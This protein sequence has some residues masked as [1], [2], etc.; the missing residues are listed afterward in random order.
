MSDDLVAELRRSAAGL[1]GREVE[2]RDLRRIP[3]GA[4]HETWSCDV[5]D[6]ARVHPVIVRRDIAGGL[7]ETDGPG[8]FALLGTLHEL[9]QPVPRQWLRTADLTVME[10]VPGRDA[11]KLMADSEREFDARD[12]GLQLVGIQAGLH[13]V[14]WRNHLSRALPAPVD[15]VERWAR[16][17]DANRVGAEPVLAAA[18]YWLG[19]NTPDPAAHVVVHGDFKANNLLVS[20]DAGAIVIDWEMT[21]L[22]DPLEDLAWTLLWDTPYD[23][24]G[25]MLS[26]ADYLCAYEQASGTTIDP[27]ALFFWEVHALVKLAGIFLTGVRPGAAQLPTLQMLGRSIPHIDR[28]IAA[29]LGL[30]L[31]REAA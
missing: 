7:L 24:V 17:V 31:E 12:I 27:E 4:S 14:D 8:E 22:G 16:V 26:R 5:H 28:L 11:R 23:L 25:G 6:G 29:R 2:V 20:R 21:H 18:I 10:R 15:E 19:A 13:A 9:G 3:G 30:A 1:L